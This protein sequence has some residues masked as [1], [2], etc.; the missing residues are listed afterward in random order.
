M[1]RRRRRRKRNATNITT[2]LEGS[3][4]MLIRFKSPKE[5]C[6]LGSVRV[7]RTV[8]RIELRHQNERAD[9]P[10]LN[11]SFGN[12]LGDLVRKQKDASLPSTSVVQIWWE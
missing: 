2:K 3:S 5:N 4:E 1:R 11:L 7:S 10:P 8:R 12:S 6:T 9:G